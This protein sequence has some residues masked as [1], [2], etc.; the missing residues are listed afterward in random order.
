MKQGITPQYWKQ[1][2]SGRYFTKETQIFSPL[3]IL[4]ETLRA[5]PIARN[6]R[7]LAFPAIHFIEGISREVGQ[8]VMQSFSLPYPSNPEAHIVKITEDGIF[9]HALSQRGLFYGSISIIQMLQ[10]GYLPYGLAY[11]EPVCSERG[12]KVFLPSRKNMDFF[13]QFVDMLAF[14]KYNT[15]MIEIGGAMEYK[16]HPEINQEWIKY[17]ADMAEYSGKTKEIQD[18]TFPWYKNAIHMENGDGEFL[19]QNDVKDLVLYC[20]ERF[21]EVIPEVPSLGHCDYLMLGHPEIAE[22]PEDPYPDTYCPS[23]PASYELLFD[24]LDEI[25]EVFE[26]E[27]INIGHDEYYSI[28]MCERCK[29]KAGADIFAE[30]IIKIY[31]YLKQKNVR[32]MIWGDKLLKNAIVP[33]AGPF[34]GAEIIMYTPQFKKDT[35]KKVGIMPAT[36]QAIQQIPKDVEILHWLWSLDEKLEDEVLEEGFTIRYGNFEGYLFPHWAEHLKKGSK[37]AI[38]SNWSTLNEVILQ[39][40]VIFFGLAYAYEMF[41]NHD[42][43]D[44]DYATIRDKTLSY[45][46]H[47]HYPDL[48]NHT[49]SLETL[50]HPS[51]IEIGYATDYFVEYQWFVDGVFPEMETYQIGNILLTYADQTEFTVPIIFGENIGK[52]SVEWNRSTNTKPLPGEPIYKVD[53]QLFEVSLRTKPYQKEQQTFFAFPIQ[54]PYPEKELK[55]VEVQTEADKDCQIFVDQIAY[56]H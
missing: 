13:K 46:F 17:C 39:R 55:N 1:E 18:Y 37:G 34:G 11:D 8:E 47:Y 28:A 33:D 27:V 14:F 43:R 30:D 15:L 19:S 56:Y 25:I 10:D 26:P 44:E 29:G 41:W 23:N 7:Q 3:P 9:V 2:N 6:N 21:F 24:V 5:H 32:T 48:Q 22:I 42:Y 53:E 50:A 38:I 16:K 35:G 36:W 49:R 45:L 52:T 54:N 12:L 20:K 40:N 4:T 51:W 31:D